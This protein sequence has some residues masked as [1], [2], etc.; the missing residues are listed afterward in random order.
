LSIRLSP[1]NAA[2]GLVEHIGEPGGVPDHQTALRQAFADLTLD[3]AA[4]R[5]VGHRVVHGGAHFTGP[6]LVD[7]GA[8]DA[9]RDLV[10]LAPLA[11][12]GTGFTAPPTTTWPSRL[13]DSSAAPWIR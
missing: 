10:P 2:A 5:A 13:R 7:D 4:I 12:A 3:P 11:S 6:T 9:I 1:T 8:L